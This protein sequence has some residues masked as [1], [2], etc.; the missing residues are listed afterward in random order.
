MKQIPLTQGMFAVVDDAD[1]PS[2]I[3]HRWF[4]HKS[5]RNVYAVRSA[6]NGIRQHSKLI[7]M[8]REIL[9]FPNGLVVD[10]INGD[11]LLNT[12]ENLRAISNRENSF[13]RRFTASPRLQGKS[14]AYK[15]V[16]RRKDKWV[17]Q[18]ETCGKKFHIGTFLEENDAAL[19]YNESAKKYF[20]EYAFLNQVAV[21][22]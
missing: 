17:A 6:Y 22:Q 20:G 11:G 2:L 5:N 19:A 18:I 1:F 16:Y 7:L 15:G 8:H 13:N 21:P 9:G 4:P 12:R 10:H 3:Q 14:S